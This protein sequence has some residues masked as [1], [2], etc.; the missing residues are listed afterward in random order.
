M[1]TIGTFC[2]DPVIKPGLVLK[3]G[4]NEAWV[5]VA[6][7][8]EILVGSLSLFV[9]VQVRPA[10]ENEFDRWDSIHNHFSWNPEQL[11]RYRQLR[12]S[13]PVLPGIPREA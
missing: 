8:P 11:D 1:T 10:K 3:K 5:V 2:I 12:C 4:W 13:F 6:T 7:K 9:Q